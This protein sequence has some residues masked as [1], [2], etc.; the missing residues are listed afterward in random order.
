MCHAKMKY[1]NILNCD[2][3]LYACFRWRMY[4]QAEAGVSAI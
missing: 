2:R 4:L 1:E 3:V